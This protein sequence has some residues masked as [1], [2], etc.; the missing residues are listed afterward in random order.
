MQYR[1]KTLHWLIRP[2][3]L[4]GDKKNKQGGNQINLFLWIRGYFSKILNLMELLSI[5]KT[6]EQ[7]PLSVIYLIN[8][9]YS[10]A[11][12]LQKIGVFSTSDYA[13]DSIKVKNLAP[14]V[15]NH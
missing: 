14:K 7:I 13:V 6:N 11:N 3:F 12:S 4:L 15:K 2:A 8:G 5:L 1:Q 9:G 10:I